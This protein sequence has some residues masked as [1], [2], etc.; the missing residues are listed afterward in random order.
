MLSAARMSCAL[1]VFAF[2]IG[3]ATA[4]ET[5][6]STHAGVALN[7][8]HSTHF[9]AARKRRLRRNTAMRTTENSKERAYTFNFSELAPSSSSLKSISGAIYQIPPSWVWF[10]TQKS[11]DEVFMLL[12]LQKGTELFEDPNF[13]KWVTFVRAR[14]SKDPT[15]ATE[16][17]LKTLIDHYGDG[18]ELAELLVAG[19]EIKGLK[20][21]AGLAAKL[22]AALLK[23]WDNE[24]K[25]VEEVLQ[26]LALTK[27][28][29]FQNSLIL[30]LF[31]F[32]KLKYPKD[33]TAVM[34]TAF[35]KFYKDDSA[36]AKLL[37]AAT[38]TQSVKSIASFAADLQVA[39]LKKWNEEG[40][41]VEEVLQIL[42]LHKSKG[43]PFQDPLFLQ[44]FAFVRLKHPKD[45]TAVTLTAFQKFY[46]DDSAWAKL[47][48]AATETQSVKSI[49][50][51]AADLQVALLKKWNE[52]GKTVEEVLQILELHKSKGNP[53]Q[54]P[55]FLQ[56]FAFV[57]LKHPKDH[58]AVTLTAFRKFYK[59]DSAW[60]KLLVAA[61]ETKSVKSIASL[62][63]DLQVALLKKWN[64]D[65]KTV[66]EVLQI[67]E[68]HKSK[69]NPFQDPLFLQLFA[70]VR[71][72]HPKDHTAVTLT[73]FRK[74]YKDDDVWAKLLVAGTEDDSVKSIALNLL[75]LQLS[76]WTE[77]GKMVGEL[78]TLV[79]LDKSGEGLF[80]N[81]LFSQWATFIEV[82]HRNNPEAATDVIWSTLVAHYGEEG[83]LADILVTGTEIPHMSKLAVSLLRIQVRMWYNQTEKS[84]EWVF[85]I[86]RLDEIGERLF[87]SPLFLQWVTLIK[88]RHRNNPEAVTD[89]IWSTLAAHYGEE[90]ALA[91]ILVTGT[92]ISHMAKLA[93]NLLKIQF[94]RWHDTGKSV[95][96]LF[97]VLKLK[98]IEEEL[99][100][101]PRLFM[102][103]VY[104][105]KYYRAAYDEAYKA[106]T[107]AAKKSTHAVAKKRADEA[108]K[109]AL[110]AATIAPFEA[111]FLTLR[112][113]YNVDIVTR[114][115]A[116]GSQ[117]SDPEVKLVAD[118]LIKMF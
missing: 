60:A 73:A 83:A 75:W 40:K 49:A 38:E 45:H 82:R 70:F 44:L 51:F 80:Q 108:A 86:L 69:G 92:K 116:N 79:G 48:V 99:F 109:T 15:A 66:E 118:A 20:S 88:V 94:R 97:T 85:T 1:V 106:V 10:L 11:S 17:M 101:S 14:F 55:L 36:W 29:P 56:L 18:A 111:V 102:W 32:V 96:W 3:P 27:G 35:R 110:T 90:G 23:K 13:V 76:R 6:K 41:T 89:V 4:V 71:L 100:E 78:F 84:V 12:K 34:L 62:A 93:V 30:Q 81:I 52:E 117:N 115:L 63:A 74:F 28:N 53:F 19:S 24:G 72:K 2:I 105:E 43:N 98:E 46:K 107:A 25:T 37:V 21:I 9:P 57:R 91:D 103:L 68:L 112:R 77:G 58:T 47:L 31:A 8:L 39:L 59:D 26:I 67:L 87:D 42:E 95:E 64:E 114:I 16:A 22:Q 54:D 5:H 7:T 50:S 61:T 104:A 113:H 33:P 65:G